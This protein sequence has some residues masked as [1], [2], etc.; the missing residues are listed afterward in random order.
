MNRTSETCQEDKLNCP[1]Y[2]N[3]YFIDSENTL[4]KYFSFDYQ[5][6]KNQKLQ[7][8]ILYHIH[9]DFSR[10]IIFGLHN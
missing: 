4:I 5:N 2:I 10:K 7:I 3:N 8:F 9:F 6:D 1:W